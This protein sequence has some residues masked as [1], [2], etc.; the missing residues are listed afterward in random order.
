MLYT[1]TLPLHVAPPAQTLNCGTL[2]PIEYANTYRG[3]GKKTLSDDV[4]QRRTICVTR[5]VNPRHHTTSSWSMTIHMPRFAKQWKSA[6]RR[7][8]LFPVL[9]PD[10]GAARAPHGRHASGALD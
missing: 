6:R 7:A 1:V 3:S 9:A 10:G 8:S 2:P 4:G 5:V